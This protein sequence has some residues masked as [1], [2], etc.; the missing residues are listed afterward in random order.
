MSSKEGS[1][2]KPMLHPTLVLGVDLIVL[3]IVILIIL[4]GFIVCFSN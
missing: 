2:N 3:T 1:L 4:I